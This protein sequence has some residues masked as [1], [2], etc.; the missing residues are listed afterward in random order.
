[1]TNDPAIVELDRLIEALENTIPANPAAPA[2]EKLAAKVTTTLA[3][4]FDAIARAIDPD[5]IDAIYY[6]HVEAE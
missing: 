3:R 4:Y 5:A 1:M 2:N 6:R